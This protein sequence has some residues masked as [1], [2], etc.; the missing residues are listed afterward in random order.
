MKYAKLSQSKIIIILQLFLTIPFGF[1]HLMISTCTS[2]AATP[3]SEEIAER[4][5]TNKVL[6]QSKNKKE[7]NYYF[8]HDNFGDGFGH[9]LLD[10]ASGMVFHFVNNR[11]GCYKGRE[12]Y[13]TPEAIG[14]GCVTCQEVYNGLHEKWAS[15]ILAESELNDTLPVKKFSNLW[16]WVKGDCNEPINSTFHNPTC[17]AA[18]LKV[19]HIWQELASELNAKHN[20]PQIDIAVH[21]RKGDFPREVS[22]TYFDIIHSLFPCP[23]DQQIQIDVFTEFEHEANE[24]KEQF[25]NRSQYKIVEHNSEDALYSWLL[26]A[27]AKVLFVHQSSFSTSAARANRHG[28]LFSQEQKPQQGR[29]DGIIFPC[30]SVGGWWMSFG[31]G[32]TSCDK[33]ALVTIQHAV[34]RRFQGSLQE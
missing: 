28:L 3:T 5:T 17:D 9:Q 14:H 20:V 26:M 33:E 34:Q 7:C 32:N 31:Y 23:S 1:R 15:Q 13:K 12:A 11:G 24:F 29:Y 18:R 25:G 21:I 2:N 16:G 10:V 27:Q 6:K 30:P 4:P 22:A 19:A 8:M